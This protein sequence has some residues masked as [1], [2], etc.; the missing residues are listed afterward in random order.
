M[1]KIEIPTELE[2]EKIEP[3]VNELVASHPELSWVDD[4]REVYKKVALAFLSEQDKAI[5]IA[6]KEEEIAGVVMASITD[7]GPL[8]GNKKIGLINILI[9]LSS[10]RRKGIGKKLCEIIMEWFSEQKIEE[11]TLFNTVED[12][13]AKTFW[14]SCGFEI[15]LEQRR[16]K[17]NRKGNQK[18]G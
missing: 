7:N 12:K 8:Q 3:L 17:I 16:K 10:Y 18:N 6:K 4:Y 14:E 1:V 9:V 13:L 15:F 2:I 11:V 5:F